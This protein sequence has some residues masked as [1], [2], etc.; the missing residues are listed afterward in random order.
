[1]KD[2]KEILFTWAF[3]YFLF[4]T[5]LIFL[6]LYGD[7][8]QEPFSHVIAGLLEWSILFLWLY[9]LLKSEEY[10]KKPLT[11]V[12]YYFFMHSLAFFLFGL[13]IFLE[14]FSLKLASI[15]N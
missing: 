2:K 1:M 9:Y 10:R 15:G 4:S 3:I 11:Y 13:D 12:K 14:P 6:F 7:I 5:S 8:I